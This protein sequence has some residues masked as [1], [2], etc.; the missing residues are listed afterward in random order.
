MNY[1]ERN[2]RNLFKNHHINGMEKSIS[3]VDSLEI[4][5]SA[6]VPPKSLEIKGLSGVF[7]KIDLLLS[8]LD[9]FKNLDNY[10]DGGITSVYVIPFPEE[11]IGKELTFSLKEK[12][13]M[14]DISFELC[15]GIGL[16]VN[17]ERLLDYNGK[18]S[19]K[20]TANYSY[21]RFTGIL[22]LSKISEF[23]Q[24]YSVSVLSISKATSPN[25][26][27]PWSIKTLGSSNV[28]IKLGEHSIVAPKSVTVSGQTVPLLFTEWDKLTVDG[29]SKRVIYTEGS[30][31]R[32]MRGTE[33][34]FEGYW[35]ESNGYG[36]QYILA[37]GRDYKVT[38]A[39]YIGYSN[40]F[41]L[42]RWANEAPNNSFL[43]S[44]E[45]TS[46]TDKGI[47][48]VYTDKVSPVAD[49]KA[50]LAEKYAEGNPLI[51][52]VKRE[53]SNVKQHDITNTDFGQ[54]LL[55]MRVPAE[56]DSTLE[57]KGGL[58][59]VPLSL[60]YYSCKEA[61]VVNITIRYLDE[62]GNEIGEPRVNKTRKGSKYLIVAPHIDGYTRVSSETYGVAD[63]D[64]EIILEYR[65]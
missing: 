32:A 12:T 42:T 62:N 1:F 10:I 51:F 41:A 57:I 33:R 26:S 15:D 49:F 2:R 40:S 65:R 11:W 53:A 50:M 20:T 44:S 8:H 17:S 28:E 43:V 59:E 35:S 14:Q 39:T 23:W 29:E 3:G 48:Q 58:D 16:F 46:D 31:Q 55:S 37:T 34:W 7:P 47:I 30:W 13:K 21:F 19:E 4:K 60:A 64:T 52:L 24:N 25:P 61:D 18:V 56:A 5:A 54:A 45:A 27:D 38:P 22:E 9:Y 6:G 36:K 63:S